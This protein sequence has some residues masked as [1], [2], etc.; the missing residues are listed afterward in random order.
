MIVILHN[1]RSV[2]N[3]GSI[4]RT[5]DALGCVEKIYLCG[6]TPSPI[7]E[8]G[9]YRNDF[10][11]ISLGAEKTISWEKRKAIFP[12]IKKL[13]KENRKVKIFAIEQSDK[14]IP[15][16]IVRKSN[17]TLKDIVLIAGEERKGIPLST[18]I[19]ADSI[20]EIPMC[21]EKESLNVSIAFAIVSFWIKYKNFKDR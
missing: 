8:M 20:I 6:I 10:I 12:L 1:I 2:Y 14:S 9:E 11:K 3:V 4:F 18:L 21:G 13:R 17:R 7:N 15:F 19:L 16:Y 5:A